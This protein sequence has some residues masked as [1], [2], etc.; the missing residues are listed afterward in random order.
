MRFQFIRSMFLVR[1]AGTRA[2][3][4]RLCPK[5]GR[6]VN[7]LGGCD[8]MRCGQDAHGGNVQNGCGASFSWSSARPYNPAAVAAAR[9]PMQVVREED[10]IRG[11]HEGISCSLC[12]YVNIIRF[13]CVS[14]SQRDT[15]SSSLDCFFTQSYA[16][17]RASLR[18][19]ALSVH[20]RRPIQCLPEVRAATTRARR[21]HAKPRILH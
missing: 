2:A 16:N 14:C 18:V 11:E 13:I 6:V 17:R 5:C 9:P 21:A 19:P 20:S 12:G 3:N 1:S 4:C 8:S 15:R 7:K 10:M